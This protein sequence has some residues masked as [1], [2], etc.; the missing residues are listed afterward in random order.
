MN[1]NAKQLELP[2]TK[3]I[4]KDYT[5]TDPGFKLIGTMNSLVR[6]PVEGKALDPAKTERPVNVIVGGRVVIGGRLARGTQI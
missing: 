6:A 3:P 4:P 2:G 5:W 1:N